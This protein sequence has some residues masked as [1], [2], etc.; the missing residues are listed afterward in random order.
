MFR[1]FGKRKK[2]PPEIPPMTRRGQAVLFG[3]TSATEPRAILPSAYARDYRNN[4]STTINSEIMDQS[5]H[6]RSILY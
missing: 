6:L 5:F 3:C 2:T 4:A 1:T